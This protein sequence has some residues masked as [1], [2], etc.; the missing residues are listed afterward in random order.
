MM[1]RVLSL[2]VA[3][4]AWLVPPAIAAEEAH[5]HGGGVPVLTL[6]FSAINLLIF[7]AILGRMAAPGIRVWV[8]ARRNTVVSDLE[9]AAAARGDAMRLKAEWEEKVAT[10]DETIR[11]MREQARVDADRE[12]DRILAHA[13]DVATAIQRDA[14]R[15]IAA[16]LRRARAELRA[17]IA[18]EAVKLAEDEVRKKWTAGDQQRFVAEFVKQVAK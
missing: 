5:G 13:R 15:T 17:E 12:R 9:D 3:G 4:L 11:Q 6:V 16:E 7:I 8:R 10:L 18:R 1:G 14:E 2:A